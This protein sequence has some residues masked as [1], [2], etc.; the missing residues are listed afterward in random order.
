MNQR[1]LALDRQI[2]GADDP[3]LTDALEDLEQIREKRGN[4]PQAE[5][6]GREALR[7]DEAW[8]GKDHPETADMMTALAGTLVFESKYIEADQLL[9]NALATQ[10]RVYGPLSTKVAFILNGMELLALKRNDMKAALEL[11]NQCIDRQAVDGEIDSAPRSNFF[12]CDRAAH[13]QLSC[14]RNLRG[15]ELAYPSA[16]QHQEAY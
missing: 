10:K 7:I 3:H 9:Q 5:Q 16:E 4:Y 2:Y 14:R 8:Y 15:G 11:N 12:E 6:Y 13:R 1:L